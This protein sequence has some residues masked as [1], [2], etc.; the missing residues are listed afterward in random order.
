[1][2]AR[3]SDLAVVNDLVSLVLEALHEKPAAI[4]QLFLETLDPGWRDDTKRAGILFP[5]H[6]AFT[7]FGGKQLSAQEQGG[8]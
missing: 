4:V 2:F 3:R 8:E 5:A 7:I 1:M 6:L